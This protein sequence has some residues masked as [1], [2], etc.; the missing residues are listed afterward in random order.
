MI[1][2]GFSNSK[3]FPCMELVLVIFQVFHD[4][5]G[6]NPVKDSDRV[7]YWADRSL[8]RVYRSFSWLYHKKIWSF[9]CN[10]MFRK[11][12]QHHKKTLH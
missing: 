8:H 4:F 12:K 5:T 2:Q 9:E 6:L 7:D 10:M 3:I 1:I 11:S